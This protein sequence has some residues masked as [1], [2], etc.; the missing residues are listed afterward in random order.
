MT[1]GL[2]RQRASGWLTAVAVAASS[3]L[4]SG[5]AS[6]IVGLADSGNM[7][8]IY[9]ATAANDLLLAHKIPVYQSPR[10]TVTNKIEYNCAGKTTAGE[11]ITATVPDGSIDD[12][13]MTLSVGTKQLYK[14]SVQSVIHDN[15]RVTP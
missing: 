12:P 13:I 4:L 7:N 5:C 10:C 3:V 15:A 1:P 6:T 9:L 14:G 8:V 11:W 2:P